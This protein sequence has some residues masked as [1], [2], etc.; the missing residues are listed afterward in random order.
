M[1]NS[2]GNTVQV[3]TR[4]AANTGFDAG[5]AVAVGA[6]PLNLAAADFDANG[7]PDLAVTSNSTGQVTILDGGVTPEAPIALERAYGIAVA[8]FNGDKKPD[9]AA[10]SDTLNAF[11]SFLNTT[12]SAQQPPVVTPTP[13]PTPIPTPVAGKSVNAT[14]VSGKVKVKLPRQQELRRSLAG[15][16][17]AG[18][19]ECGHARWAGD[20]PRR[21][22][23]AGRRTS[24][25]GCSR[26][27]RRRARSR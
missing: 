21:R 5:A 4:N 25:T 2:A 11:V 6:A 13:T 18:R 16:E 1:S 19:D 7:T 15:R 12:P 20:D 8:D 9:L 17:P 26:S 10:S 24:T 23:R 14:P 27:A 3:L 22:A